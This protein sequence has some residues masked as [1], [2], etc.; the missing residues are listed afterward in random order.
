M[1][2][3]TRTLGVSDQ[4]LYTISYKGWLARGATLSTVLVTVPAGTTSSIGAITTY[5]NEECVRFFVTGGVLNEQFTATIVATD[6]TGQVVHD[7]MQ[8]MVIAP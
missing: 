4:R 2:L 7:T 5:P 6:S 1:L 8:F 3:A